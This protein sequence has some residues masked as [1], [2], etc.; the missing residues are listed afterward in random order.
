VEREGWG[1]SRGYEREGTN[2]RIRGRGKQQ[3]V[4]AEPGGS[5][6]L[7]ARATRT[8]NREGEGTELLDESA[9]TRGE[10]RRHARDH[11]KSERRTVTNPLGDRLKNN[12]RL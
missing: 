9:S 12:Q 5:F 6:K 2:A 7:H 10:E 3:K 8:H 4:I 11:L 1:E